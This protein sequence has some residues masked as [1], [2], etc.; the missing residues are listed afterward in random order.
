MTVR[1]IT[2]I[3]GVTLAL[4]SLLS[5][6]FFF[7]RGEGGLTRMTSFTGIYAICKPK[8]YDVVCFGDTAGKDGGV[9]CVPL[10]DAGGVCR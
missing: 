4:A 5:F 7:L 10:K 2:V 6:W 1:T 3:A 8:G 9:A